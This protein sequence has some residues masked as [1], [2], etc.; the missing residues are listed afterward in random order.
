MQEGEEEEVEVVGEKE[1]D[2]THR[3][4][5]KIRRDV[6]V[7]TGD[8]VTRFESLPHGWRQDRGGLL[9]PADRRPR[10]ASDSVDETR[11]E[12]TAPPRLSARSCS[13]SVI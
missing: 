2:I 7:Q 5:K 3:T 8:A 6:G 9:V 12:T 4:S 10:A 1:A 11:R 13:S